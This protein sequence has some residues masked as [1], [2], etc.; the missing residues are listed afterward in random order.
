MT[1]LTPNAAANPASECGSSSHAVT[2]HVFVLAGV[3]LYRE[4]IAA[5]L[6]ND[7]RFR[8]VGAAADRAALRQL[9]EAA[10]DVVLME[11]G[12]ADA[13]ALVRAIRAHAPEAKVVALGISEDEADVLPLAEAGIAGWVTRDASVDDLREAVASAAAGETLCSPR[14]V[15]SLLRRVA[16]LAEDLRDGH[17]S[18]SLTRRQREIVALID[19]GL[20]NKE[21]ARQLSIELPT[22]KNHVHNIL[23]KLQVSRRGEAAALVRAPR[24]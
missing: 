23:E 10:P 1:R 13:P 2:A 17:A 4:G 12:P 11:A 22:V 24:N 5:A 9:G 15:A 3:R 18:R 6:A 14:M 7:D 21:I 8:V 20:S 16:S 19:A